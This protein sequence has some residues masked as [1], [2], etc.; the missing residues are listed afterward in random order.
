MSQVTE[1]DLQR[2]ASIGYPA[3]VCANGETDAKSLAESVIRVLENPSA[4]L[5]TAAAMAVGTL[6]ESDELDVFSGLD[7]SDNV[8]RRLGYLSERLSVKVT[9]SE[10]LL[11][12]GAMLHKSNDS[13][14]PWLTFMAKT[15]PT[16]IRLQT[17]R[18]DALNHR[19]NVLGNIAFVSK[20][21]EHNGDIR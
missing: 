15:T 4:R 18:A 9:A 7:L 17:E 6:A 13:Q 21:K 16:F 3:P 19:W 14:S 1:R 8:R 12:F 5:T 20:A 10:R 2:F 11:A